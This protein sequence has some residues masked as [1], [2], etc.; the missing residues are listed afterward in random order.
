[1]KTLAAAA[2]PTRFILLNPSHPGNVGA[3]AR[4][5]KVMG[6]AEQNINNSFEFAQKLVRAKDIQE[7]LLLQQQ[8]LTSQL[9]AMQAQ[10]K[11]LGATATKAATDSAK[12]KG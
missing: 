7:V 3:A 12:P 5:I 8:F 9:Q 1:M 10:A 6:F 2:D 4:A 11:D